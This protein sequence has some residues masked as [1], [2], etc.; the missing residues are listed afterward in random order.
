[1]MAWTRRG[2][3]EAVPDLH[4]LGLLGAALSPAAAVAQAASA[5]AAAT[6]AIARIQAVDPR[7]H[8][9]KHPREH[10]FNCLNHSDDRAIVFHP[11]T[12]RQR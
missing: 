3:A 11:R 2:D 9:G 4:Q 1:M 8:A 7:V 6:A 12:V 10:A 5:E